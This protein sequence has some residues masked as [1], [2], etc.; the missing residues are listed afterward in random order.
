VAPSQVLLLSRN[1][2][3]TPPKLQRCS[4]SLDDNSCGKDRFQRWWPAQTICTH[5]QTPNLFSENPTEH[6]PKQ[7]LLFSLFIIRSKESELLQCRSLGHGQNVNVTVE[8][9]RD[10]YGTV[11]GKRPLQT[12]TRSNAVMVW[13]S[14]GA[15]VLVLARAKTSVGDKLSRFNIRRTSSPPSPSF[16][17]NT[18]ATSPASYLRCERRT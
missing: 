3:H 6:A 7:S 8:L 4:V 11:P 15:D 1:R 9:Y 13:G 5:T 2:K 14:G 18:T 17:G 16:L 10:R 12:R